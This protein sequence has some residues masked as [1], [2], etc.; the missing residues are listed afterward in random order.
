MNVANTYTQI[1]NQQKHHAK[2][3]FLDEYCALLEKYHVEY[4]PRYIFKPIDG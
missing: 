2:K 3:S 1:E 4:D